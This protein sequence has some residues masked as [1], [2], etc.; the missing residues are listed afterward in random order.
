MKHIK[1][2]EDFVNEKNK[3]K[4]SIGDYINFDNEKARI[5]NVYTK[6][7]KDMYTIGSSTHGTLEIDAKDVDD[8]N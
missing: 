7:G 6:N 3:H 2:Y 5:D 1:L 4:F 8:N